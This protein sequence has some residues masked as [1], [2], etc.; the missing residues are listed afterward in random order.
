MLAFVTSLRHPHNSADY[1][2]VEALLLQTLSSLAGQLSPTFR[3]VVVGNREPAAALPAEAEFVGVDWAAPSDVAGPQTSREAVL[4]DKGTKLAL[5]ALAALPHDPTHVMCV[6]ADDFVSRQL[7]GLVAGDP[8]ASGWVV[9]EGY[10]YSATRRLVRPQSRFNE[11]CGTSLVL[12]TS[13]LVPEGHPARGLGLGVSQ[14][15]LVET[16][17][18]FT[19]RELFGSHR[20]AVEHFAAGGHPLR[21]VPFPGAVYRVDTGENHSGSSLSGFARPVTT[22]LHEEFGLPLSVTDP[23]VLTGSLVSAARSVAGRARRVITRGASR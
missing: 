1:T 18:D 14:D 20:R 2:R 17:G 21:S 4:R 10:V 22:A 3:I 13:L 12:R 11:K 5:G 16:L 9:D 23:A 8:D 19:V 7:S 15:E 6:D